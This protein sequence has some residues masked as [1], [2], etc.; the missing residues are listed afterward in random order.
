MLVAGFELRLDQRDQCGALRGKRERRREHRGKP[1]KARIAGN[2]FDRFGYE[3]ARQR[4]RIHA[5]AH[6]DT[7]ILAQFP[8]ELTVADIDGIYP[9]STAL[10]QHV[11][12][13]A[14]RGPDV[15]C[16]PTG[17]VDAEMVKGVGKLDT[18]A[19]DP[20][21]V[22]ALERQR[23]VDGKLMAGFVDPP[24]V[25]VDEPRKDERLRFGPAFGQPAL[26]QELINPLLRQSFETSYARAGCSAISRPST[27][28]A[29]ATMWRALSPACS[30]C[31]C[32]L[33]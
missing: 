20:R 23:S 2:N 11:G 14:G 32:G 24:I 13:P 7:R 9:L 6:D 22:A 21:V 16:N 8:G 19:R 4:T 30:Y 31:A 18:A 10:H 27:D 17:Y 3:R 29:I 28:K 25:G 5:L 33:S 12:K 1:N 26:D 15:E